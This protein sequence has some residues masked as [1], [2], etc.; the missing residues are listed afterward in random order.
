LPACI[1]FVYD[2]VYIFIIHVHILV[3]CMSSVISVRIKEEV[4]RILEEE[5]IDIAKEVR[6]FLEE[7][8]LKVRLRRYVEKWSRLLEDV[9]SS[10]K[11]FAVRSV[12]KD[13]ESH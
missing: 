6:R 7:L 12:R 8:A 4:K 11:G 13:R 1:L 5:G 3:R 2:N 9:T 10:E